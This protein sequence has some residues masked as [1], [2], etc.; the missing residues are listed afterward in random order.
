MAAAPG[1]G[2][3]ADDPRE[4]DVPALPE[5]HREFAHAQTPP[6]HSFAL[7]LDKLPDPAITFSGFRAHGILPGI[8]ATKC[9]DA[10][11]C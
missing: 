8:G 7:D 10:G 4:P 11:P 5:R 6:E 1:A 9:P 2:L 3:L